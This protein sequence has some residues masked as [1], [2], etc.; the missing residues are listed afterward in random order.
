MK[1]APYAAGVAGGIILL[2]VIIKII[3]KIAG[4]ARKPKY[5]GRH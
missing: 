4:K 3:V 2:V 5:T 1:Y